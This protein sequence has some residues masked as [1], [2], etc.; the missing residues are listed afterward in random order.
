M[1]NQVIKRR[2]S[3]ADIKKMQ[4]LSESKD[5]SEI[6]RNVIY[7]AYMCA[8]ELQPTDLALYTCCAKSSI[9]DKCYLTPNVFDVNTISFSDFEEISLNDEDPAAVN[10]AKHPSRF[11]MNNKLIFDAFSNKRF[12]YCIA[13]KNSFLI[14]VINLQKSFSFIKNTS[15]NSTQDFSDYPRDYLLLNTGFGV[16]LLASTIEILWILVKVYR[17]IQQE[18]FLLISQYYMRL[19]SPESDIRRAIFEEFLRSIEYM[20]VRTGYDFSFYDPYEDKNESVNK[21]LK[22]QLDKMQQNSPK[23]KRKQSENSRMSLCD[24]SIRQAAFNGNFVRVSP[25]IVAEKR[26]SSQLNLDPKTHWLPKEKIEELPSELAEEILQKHRDSFSI[27]LAQMNSSDMADR[28]YPM[29]TTRSGTFSEME[30]SIDHD[31]IKKEVSEIHKTLEKASTID[32]QCTQ[33]PGPVSSILDEEKI[34]QLERI[35]TEDVHN[36]T[37]LLS[38]NRRLSVSESFDNSFAEKSR[39]SRA[40]SLTENKSRNP[41]K[42]INDSNIKD[43]KETVLRKGN[44]QKPLAVDLDNLPTS[45]SSV[46]S[47]ANI[48]WESP[49]FSRNPDGSNQ[50]TQSNETSQESDNSRTNK[51]RTS[52]REKVANMFKPKKS[53]PTELK[54]THLSDIK[55]E[56][57][58]EN[59]A[60]QKSDNKIQKSGKKRKTKSFR[61]FFSLTKT[62]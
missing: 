4:N 28:L 23:S 49:K 51:K 9:S 32:M 16:F 50:S 25:E 54:I 11:L 13:L 44:N 3:V 30:L 61:K 6:R 45:S 62:K 35:G 26:L 38:V 7:A 20:G 1:N 10:I 52:F 47:F 18:N 41:F 12:N 59:K 53:V 40:K 60:P 17:A 33:N 58:D 19:E 43:Y 36:L 8:F 24:E 5:D 39:L 29:L 15:I 14:Q 22:G 31:S 55:I 37:A 57:P 2:S 27:D 48:N 42:E 21:N 34:E 46:D 56:S